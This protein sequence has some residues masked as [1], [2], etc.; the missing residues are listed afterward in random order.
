M[1]P[2]WKLESRIELE[3]KTSAS[4]WDSN[5]PSRNGGNV[6]EGKKR[7]E[8]G[9]GRQEVIDWKKAAGTTVPVM[10]GRSK[11]NRGFNMFS[12]AT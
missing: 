12:A 6:A 5:V 11:P 10:L 7:G 2:P 9:R 3:N 8:A 1:G 4:G